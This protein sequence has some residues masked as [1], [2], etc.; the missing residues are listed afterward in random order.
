MAEFK[1]KK[2]VKYFSYFLQEKKR[3]EISYEISS[4]ILLIEKK[5]NITNMFPTNF[6][7]GILK[8]NEF[9]LKQ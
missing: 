4:L 3:I 1:H 2:P 6:E 5:K 9:L 8:I 7:T